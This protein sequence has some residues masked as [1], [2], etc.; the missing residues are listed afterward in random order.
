MTSGVMVTAAEIA[1][2]AGVG[3]AA[4]SNWRRRHPDFP[5]P[6]AGTAASPQF[7]LDEVAAWL[8]EHGRVVTV[9]PL[10]ELW[11]R[12]NALRD[13]SRPAVI[14]AATGA[15]IAGDRPGGPD[16]D[17][18][19]LP[20]DFVDQVERLAADLGASAVFEGLLDRWIQAHARQ[21]EVTPAPVAALMAEVVA[22]GNG[23]APRTVLDPAC[24]TGG[25]LDAMASRGAEVLYGQDADPD[26]AEVA[27]LRLGLGAGA[28]SVLAAGDSLLDDAFAGRQVQAVVCNPPFGQRS[29]GRNELGYDS[30]WSYGLPPNTEPEL[31]WVQHAL[32][33]LESGG[34]AAVL[35]PAAAAAR[36]SGRRIR[37]E[38]VR[39]GA[40]RAVVALPPG[41]SSAHG[42]G[43]H[44]WL[45]GPPDS[46]EPPQVLFVDAENVPSAA[47]AGAD[48]WPLV[49]RTVVSTWRAFLGGT[50]SDTE[51]CRILPAH[52]LLDNEVNLTPSRYVHELADDA[53]DLGQLAED[54]LRF[55]LDLMSLSDGP[56]VMAESAARPETLASLDDLVRTGAVRMWRGP[57]RRD[58]AREGSLEHPVIAL[59]QG[60]SRTAPTERVLALPEE[61][62]IEGDVLM[63]MGGAG[64]TRPADPAE[65]G[66]VPG[67]G[68][69]VLRPDP[70]VVDSWFL[71]GSLAS[72]AN[73]R[74][75][76]STSGSASRTRIDSARLFVPIRDLG[77]QQRIGRAFQQ[78]VQFKEALARLAG[79]GQDLAQRLQD[80]LADGSAGP[81]E[82][83]A[84]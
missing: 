80:A 20:Q 14:L 41:A 36:P 39:R 42:M 29:W 21:V 25:L 55:R 32:A 49:H 18:A 24:G 64:G 44:L 58:P 69:T 26:L 4:V 84:D 45:A 15:V 37:A 70:S 71:V 27:R 47:A 54:C 3:P 53:V 11:R 43:T 75:A 34:C 51:V 13:P 81:A 50:G 2:I 35:M 38:L 77:E 62:V 30:R 63:F 65:Y 22:V 12:M 56:P 66:A 78:L 72:G 67:P 17:G 16:G 59:Q 40:L 9:S 57:S 60:I 1:R 31:A 83:P 76:G 52:S 79:G 8:R 68:V 46:S 5:S 82:Q 7:S 33:H 48:E 23:A 28:E 19:G 10:G 6:M 74:I 73:R 61:A